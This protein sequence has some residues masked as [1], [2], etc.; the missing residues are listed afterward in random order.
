MSDSDFM[1]IPIG[2]KGEDA[3]G[4]ASSPKNAVIERTI[5]TIH[6]L[7]IYPNGNIYLK[8][9]M[10]WMDK[11][12]NIVKKKEKKTP[13]KVKEAELQQEEVY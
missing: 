4:A 1:D 11:K 6:T 3:V 12:G 9:P 13:M 7:I 10:S 2:N 8:K 5:H